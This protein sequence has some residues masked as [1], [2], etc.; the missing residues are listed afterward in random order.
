MDL[1]IL[2]DWVHRYNAEGLEGLHNR[3][4]PGAKPRLSPEQ[5]REV[6]ELVR[7]GPNLA[8]HGVVRWRRIDLSHVI[9]QRYGVKLAERSVGDLLRRQTLLA[10]RV[11]FHMF[12]I[13]DVL[14][15]RGCGRRLH[16]QQRG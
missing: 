1:Q 4:A 7:K 2:C 3:T 16:G 9:E 11:D 5:E 8:E 14:R 6:A 13:D 12:R 10:K 15:R